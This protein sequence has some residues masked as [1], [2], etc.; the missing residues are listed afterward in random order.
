MLEQLYLLLP[1][2]SYKVVVFFICAVCGMTFAYI[3]RWSEAELTKPLVNYLTD[4]PRAIARAFTT[5][6][7]ILGGSLVAGHLDPMNIEQIVTA[8]VGIG[9]MVPSVIDKNNTKTNR[10]VQ[11]PLP[12]LPKRK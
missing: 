7:S 1:Q 5:M 9:V 2:D 12:P 6:L 3:K 11:I 10:K 4:D 8:G